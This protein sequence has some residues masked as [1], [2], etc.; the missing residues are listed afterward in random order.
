[1]EKMLVFTKHGDNAKRA[2]PSEAAR[3]PIFS[4]ISVISV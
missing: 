3:F 2:A 4:V 1:M